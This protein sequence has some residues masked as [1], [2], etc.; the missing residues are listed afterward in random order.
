MLSPC[1]HTV[2]AF[3]TALAVATLAACFLALC[4]SYFL[5][6]L[7]RFAKQVFTVNLFVI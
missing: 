4:F 7:F 2:R 5:Q 3:G 6:S 1:C